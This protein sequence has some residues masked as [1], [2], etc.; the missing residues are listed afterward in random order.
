VW[1]KSSCVW[2]GGL[3]LPALGNL[4]GYRNRREKDREKDITFILEKCSLAKCV[5]ERERE[6]EREDIPELG[7]APILCLPS[8]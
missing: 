2:A 4:A 8:G 7:T 5:R 1:T 6:R 3:E